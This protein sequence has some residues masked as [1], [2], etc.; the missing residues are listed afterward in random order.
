MVRFVHAVV[1]IEVV[2]NHIERALDGLEHVAAE[3]AC[4]WRNARP[5]A[6]LVVG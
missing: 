3:H 4:M 1:A 5:Y 6:G 2:L